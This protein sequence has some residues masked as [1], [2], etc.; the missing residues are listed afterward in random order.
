MENQK[1]P[2]F[3]PSSGPKHDD[4]M[5]IPGNRIYLY[6]I[7][8]RE[9]VLLTGTGNNL[10]NKK[11]AQGLTMW[12]EKELVYI[13]SAKDYVVTPLSNILQ[14]VPLKEIE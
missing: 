6:S 3:Q 8:T 10:F 4:P 9:A 13:Q 2:G 14:M 7:R 5:D 1:E 11:A 12:L